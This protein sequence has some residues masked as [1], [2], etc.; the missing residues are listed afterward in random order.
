MISSACSPVRLFACSPVRLFACRRLGEEESQAERDLCFDRMTDWL[1][2]VAAVAGRWFLFDGGG[3]A[4][5]WK[6][7]VDLPTQESAG[8][9]L[10]TDADNWLASLHAAMDRGCFEQVTATALAILTV[11]SAEGRQRQILRDNMP[12]G[13]VGAGES[14]TYFIG[15][16]AT[17]EVTEQML[18][19]MFLGGATG[20]TDRIL[21]FSTAV[22]G[23]L[24]FCPSAGFL[25]EL[26]D[27]PGGAASAEAADR[28]PAPLPSAVCQGSVGQS[29]AASRAGS[30]T[31]G[32]PS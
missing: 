32:P 19:S 13:R 14:G 25:D 6:G 16:A 26:P 12:F 17:P 29:A 30:V 1:L 9:W 20:H 8:A 31:I 18:G 2:E 28:A 21:E 24:F 5:G 11:L 23:G 3:P 15:Y 10:R 22:T 4:A 27:Q 7:L